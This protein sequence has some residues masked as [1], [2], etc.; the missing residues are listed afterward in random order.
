[1]SKQLID[2]TKVVTAFSPVDCNTAPT[3][4]WV[5]LKNADRVTIILQCG[6][7]A[8]GTG[9]VITLKQATAVA[10]TGE[11]ELAFSYVYQKEGTLTTSST[12][13]K[14]TVT[15]NTFTAGTSSSIYV[16]EIRASELDVDNGFDCVRVDVAGTSGDRD[17]E[18][19]S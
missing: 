9:C 6:T 8:G 1:M 16:I 5:S 18:T 3:E 14:T 13:T 19:H 10:G 4:D 7:L 11:K 2:I 12:L 15:S 17:W